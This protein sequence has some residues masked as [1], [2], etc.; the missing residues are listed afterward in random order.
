MMKVTLFESFSRN[1]GDITLGEFLRGI[2]DGRSAGT[3]NEIRQAMREGDSERAEKLKKSLPGYTLS[4]TYSAA[5]RTE[6]LQCYN[7]IIVLDIDK[8]DP[9]E[10]EPLKERIRA[11]EY[12]MSCFRS[13]S[14]LGLKVIVRPFSSHPL[15]AMNHRI[16]FQEMIRAYEDLLGVRIDPSG[17]DVG[18]L[19]FDSYDPEIYI[20]PQLAELVEQLEAREEMPEVNSQEEEQPIATEETAATEESKEKATELPDTRTSRRAISNKLNGSRR[21]TDRVANYEPGNRNNYIYLFTHYCRRKS[22]SQEDVMAY[23]IKHFSDLAEAEIEQVVLSAYNAAE[24]KKETEGKT[25]KNVSLHEIENYLKRKYTFRHNTITHRIEVK[26]WRTKNEFQ[27]VDKTML[28]TLWWETVKA[29]VRCQFATFRILLNSHFVPSYNPFEEYFHNLPPWDG[30]TDHI[31]QVAATVTTTRPDLWQES[32]RR[33]IVAMVACA[34]EPEV[35]NQTVLV[36]CGAQGV[37]KTSWCLKLIPPELKKYIHSGPADPRSKDVRLALTECILVNLD[38]LGALGERELN[39]LKEMI[40]APIVRERRA[41]A[42][43][44]ETYARCCSFT[45]SAN[46]VQILSDLTGARRFLCF[47]TLS[48]D[49]LSPIDY[50]GLFAQALALS[51]SGHKFWFDGAEIETLHLNNETFRIQS[52]EEELFF[53]YFRLPE[54]DDTDVL[55]LS[56]SQILQHLAFKA[57]IHITRQAANN[58]SMMLR[59]QGFEQVRQYKRRVYRVVKI[60]EEEIERRR[61][62]QLPPEDKPTEDT[63]P[64]NN[65]I[66]D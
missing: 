24:E 12:T 28:H 61:K 35:T 20:H 39:Q 5:R 45:A 58:L 19:C 31:G 10:V 54:T 21:Q 33:W 49:Y 7:K 41:Y 38:E 59:K 29:G 48:I 6:H 17:K 56:T 47:E 4:A 26:R 53:T 64:Q 13:C 27:V 51:K 11:I 57:P 34:L 1:R 66:F 52:P 37:G 8:L 40:T 18:R 16:T 2:R 43:D 65:I 32:F 15:T 22:L 50:A 30:V 62:E 23:C 42:E 63:D 9:G 46:T 14:A 3:V 44:T 36:L 25:G 60:D 55:L